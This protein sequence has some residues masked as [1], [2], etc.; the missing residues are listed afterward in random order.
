[1]KTPLIHLEDVFI[2][3]IVGF[4]KCGFQLID[5]KR[6]F[7]NMGYDLPCSPLPN[8][9]TKHIVI[10]NV[11]NRKDMNQLHTMVINNTTLIHCDERGN[12]ITE[13]KKLEKKNVT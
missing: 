3:G 1:M 12:V 10:H 7:Q 2:T 4:T 13:Q 6:H 8:H 9:L 11:N 5:D